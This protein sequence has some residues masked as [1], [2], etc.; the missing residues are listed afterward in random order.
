MNRDTPISERLWHYHSLRGKVVLELEGRV[1][2]PS[3]PQY[4][5]RRRASLTTWVRILLF[6]CLC[7]TS[8]KSMMNRSRGWKSGI[9]KCFNGALVCRQDI[10]SALSRR[11]LCLGTEG[12]KHTY[13]LRC[14]GNRQAS[15]TSRETRH[16][17]SEPLQW[18]NTLVRPHQLRLVHKNG[19]SNQLVE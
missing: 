9:L 6:L 4:F 15:E 5:L 13:R 19:G 18:F 16:Q 11:D 1:E 2:R 10:G 14:W 17:I 8:P 3:E 12:R 7:V